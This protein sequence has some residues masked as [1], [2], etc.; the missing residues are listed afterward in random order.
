[1][2]RKQKVGKVILLITAIAGASY[3]V[4]NRPETITRQITPPVHASQ[5]ECEGTELGQIFGR[6]KDSIKRVIGVKIERTNTSGEI[7]QLV[8][9]R[10]L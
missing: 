3:S 6:S 9:G 1:M 5:I 8:K 7:F 4:S 2:A 10:G